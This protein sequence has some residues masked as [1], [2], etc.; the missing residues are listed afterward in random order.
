MHRKSDYENG[1]GLIFLSL[2]SVAKTSGVSRYGDGPRQPLRAR[3]ARAFLG[4]VAAV[5]P[6]A[7][8]AQGA[9]IVPPEQAR[10][11]RFGIN[12]IRI[13]G[14][15]LVPDAMLQAAVNPYIGFNRSIDDLSAVKQAILDVYRRLGYE[16]L[17]VSYQANRSR[18]GT[19]YFV[20]RELRIG[21]VRVT[22][23]SALTE[24]EIRRELPSLVEDTAPH[25][26]QLAREL[27]L[28]NDNPGRTALL[29]YSSGVPGTSDVEIKIAE[30]PQFTKALTFNNTGTAATGR[31]RIGLHAAHSNFLGRSDQ[32][33]ASVTTSDRP[34]HVLQTAFSYLMPLPSLGD[35]VQLSA[36]YSDADSGR[37]AD[38]FNVSG[39][40]TIWGAHY[41]HNLRRDARSRHVLDIGYEERRFRDVVDFSGTN[42]GVSVTARPVILGYR[43]SRSAEGQNLSLGIALQQNL[44][45]GGRNDNATYA[46]SRAGATARWK[47]WQFD[48]SWQRELSSGWMPAARF[49]A[50]YAGK[51]LIAAEQFGLGGQRAIRGFDE[52]EAAGDRGWRANFEIYGPRFGENQRLL[53][54][55][56]Y[57]GS[58]RLNPLLGEL[59]GQ[60]LASFGVGWRAQIKKDLSIS[61]DGASVIHGTT[62]HSRGHKSLHISASYSF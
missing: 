55:V 2:I 32:L 30:Q 18:A 27:F 3:I 62:R 20:V 49:A 1:G 25:L 14:N 16:L 8:L 4:V 28:F 12:E 53:G 39:K 7:G 52:R 26:R 17:T 48:G 41:L 34:S 56:D 35:S 40:G 31:A 50:Q 13:E 60:H 37:V 54:F 23:N 24:N 46:A 11:L 19:H 10:V 15:T 9:T 44:P 57:G 22:G 38:L 61:A 45:G 21:K 29:Q 42:L 59:A 6:L 33:A 51:P 5:F 43:Y 58:T 36:S 47:S